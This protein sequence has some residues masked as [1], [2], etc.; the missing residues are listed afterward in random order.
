M[1][2]FSPQPGPTTVEVDDIVSRAGEAAAVLQS[3][4]G[5][6][7]DTLDLL[8]AELARLSDINGT[9]RQQLKTAESSLAIE[10]ARANTAQASY[11]GL[12]SQH[13]RLAGA[14]DQFLGTVNSSSQVFLDDDRRMAAAVSA[15][16]DSKRDYGADAPPSFATNIPGDHA[17]FIRAF[18]VEPAMALETIIPS[19]AGETLD[20]GMSDE[21][22][23]RNAVRSVLT[24]FSGMAAPLSAPMGA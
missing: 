19:E 7:S 3:L 1:N 12:L 8:M 16:D 6:R 20:A 15:V 5:R 10:S 21:E 14:F 4:G 2:H 22:A 11:D 18:A 24:G 23:E 9:L 13:R 17:G